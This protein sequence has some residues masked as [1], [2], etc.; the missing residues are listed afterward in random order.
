MLS[1]LFMET[2]TINELV[3]SVFETNGLPLK[4]DLTKKKAFMKLLV[5]KKS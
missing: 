1:Q 5:G 4:F 2:I 3:D